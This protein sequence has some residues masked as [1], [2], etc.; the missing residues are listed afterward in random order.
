[1]KWEI[2]IV[3]F[4]IE[5][6]A[7]LYANAP[8]REW[9]KAIGEGVLPVVDQLWPH[10]EEI[11]VLVYPGWGKENCLLDVRRREPPC[12]V[13]I[14]QAWKSSELRARRRLAEGGKGGD[15]CEG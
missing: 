9:A 5:P 1:M 8:T 11:R 7:V 6:L 13:R 4:S 2:H 15:P 12:K 10:E 14:L 3:S